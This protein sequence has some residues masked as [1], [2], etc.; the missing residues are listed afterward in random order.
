[1]K[2]LGL[3]LSLQRSVGGS[4]FGPELVTNGAFAADASW[5]KGAGWT[6]AGGVAVATA[7]A[8]GVMISSAV[9][10]GLSTSKTYRVTFDVLNRSAG[11]LN[12]RL[13]NNTLNSQV[14]VAPSNGTVSFNIQP[15]NVATDDI[16]FVANGATTLQ[17]D[18]VSVK[19]IL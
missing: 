16:S 1:M 3:G 14:G 5:T 10:L 4:S 7:V 19:E 13:G 11:D 6:I 12:L 15:A 2:G 17:I 18:N 9:A 8:N